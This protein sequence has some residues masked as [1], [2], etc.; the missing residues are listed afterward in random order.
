M[1]GLAIGVAVAAGALH[2]VFDASP[3]VDAV[4]ATLPVIT[5]RYRMHPPSSC[6]LTDAAQW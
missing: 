1:L 2:A 4:G 3:M 5:T 6:Q